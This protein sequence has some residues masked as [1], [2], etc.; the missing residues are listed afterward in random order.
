MDLLA[1]LAQKVLGQQQDI[2]ATLAQ[3]RHQQVEVVG[4]GDLAEGVARGRA[5][6]GVQACPALPF[7]VRLGDLRGKGVVRV[8]AALVFGLARAQFG[9]VFFS[10][11][12]LL[13][14]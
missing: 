7:L 4:L 6:Q 3:R 11:G 14:E 9:E 2:H 12:Q 1:G 8:L 13:V 10:I 5:D